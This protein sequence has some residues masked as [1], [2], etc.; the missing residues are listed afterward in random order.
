M[1]AEQ[2]RIGARGPDAHVDRSQAAGAAAV[3]GHLVGLAVDSRVNAA[4]FEVDTDIT[5]GRV[6]VIAGGFVVLVDAAAWHE[7]VSRRRPSKSVPT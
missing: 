2:A 7:V 6:R 1:R 4:A 5:P 3:I